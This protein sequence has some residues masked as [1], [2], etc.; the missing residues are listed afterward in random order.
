MAKK[1]TRESYGAA[2]Q[3][4]GKDE[5]IVVLDADLSKSTKTE[6]FK[7]M[8]PERF[9]NMG[10]AEANMM[11][12]AAGLAACGKIVFASSFAIFAAGRASV[13]FPYPYA[14][15]DHQRFNA[16]FACR[17]GA[18]VMFD[19]FK[20]TPEMLAETVRGIRDDKERREAMALAAKSLSC[21]D[22]AHIVAVGALLVIL[23]IAVMMIVRTSIIWGGF[24]ALLEE[25]DYSRREKAENKKIA[26]IA[27][28]YWLAVTAGVLAWSFITNDWSRSWIVWPIAGVC[29]GIVAGIARMLRGKA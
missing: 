19:D 12:V 8:Y 29:F 9:I 4:I 1:A 10:I 18:S 15:A 6:M 3:E 24:A 5:R 2:L 13:L 14:Y 26:P 25:G 7:K 20:S 23:S 22:A 16:E 11:S 17:K 27:S 28:I 21:P